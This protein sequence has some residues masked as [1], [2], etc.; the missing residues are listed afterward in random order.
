M[1][2]KRLSKQE[3]E[4]VNS[5]YDSLLAKRPNE[6]EICHRALLLYTMQAEEARSFRSTAK[7]IGRSDTGVKIWRKKHNWNQRIADTDNECQQ[8]L[9]L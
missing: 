2:D 8:A 1:K 7:A 6:R 5:V 4:E 9:D 3:M